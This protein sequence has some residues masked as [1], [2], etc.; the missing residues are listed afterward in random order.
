VFG[1]ICS[2]I[3]LEFDGIPGRG[4]RGW[5]QAPN[6]TAVMTSMA[7]PRT[8]IERRDAEKERRQSPPRAPDTQRADGHLSEE[9]CGAEAEELPED[10]TARGAECQTALFFATPLGRRVGNDP[11]GTDGSE[12][13]RARR[14]QALS[15][16]PATHRVPQA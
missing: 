9:K 6:T 4:R 10:P 7:P 3:V 1:R 14:E 11:I 8:A 2:R 5:Q 15:R 12:Q 16:Q 13:Q